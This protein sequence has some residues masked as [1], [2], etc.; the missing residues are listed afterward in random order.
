MGAAFVFSL[1]AFPSES[2]PFLG[3][4]YQTWNKPLGVWQSPEQM[5]FDFSEMER[6]GLRSARV[7]WVWGE[8]EAKEG[9]FDFSLPEKMVSLAKKHHIQIQPIIGFQWPPAW[10]GPEHRLS[11]TVNGTSTPSALM[12]YSDPWVRARFARAIETTVRHFRGEKQI[13]AWILGN[14]FAAIDFLGFRQ[15]GPVPSVNASQSVWDSFLNGRREAIAQIIG[16][17]CA[18]SKRADPSAK[19]TYAAIGVLFS[20]FDRFSTSEDAGEIARA[21]RDRGAPLDFIS[22]NS[23]LNLNSREPVFLDLSPEIFAGLTGLPVR[24]SEFGVTSTEEHLPSGE[25]EQALLLKAQALS[26]LLMPIEGAAHI[27][28]W[29][30]KPFVAKRERGF[31]IRTE[32]R[33]LKPV[34]SAMEGWLTELSRYDAEELRRKMLPNSA[35]EIVFLLPDRS[36]RASRWNSFLN[37]SWIVASHFRRLGY[38]VR[39]SELAAVLANPK[40]TDVLALVRHDRMTSGDWTKLV[41]GWNSGKIAHVLI[42]SGLPGESGTWEK[43]LGFQV[44][45]LRSGKDFAAQSYLL[46]FVGISQPPHVVVAAHSPWYW[47]SAKPTGAEPFGS[48]SVAKGLEDNRPGGIPLVYVKRNTRGGSV[49]TLTVGTGYTMA[50]TE[51]V[52]ARDE[53]TMNRRSQQGPVTVTRFPDDFWTAAFREL[54]AS[55]WL[56][57]LGLSRPS[58]LQEVPTRKSWLLSETRGLEGGGAIVYGFHSPVMAGELGSLCGS[59]GKES[60]EPKSLEIAVG[61]DTRAMISM[62][63]GKRVSVSGGVFKKEL[64]LCESDVWVSAGGLARDARDISLAKDPRPYFTERVAVIGNP[65]GVSEAFVRAGYEM[66]RGVAPTYHESE[67][68]WTVSSPRA[69]QE[70]APSEFVSAGLEEM[71]GVFPQWRLSLAA[72]SEMRSRALQ[73]ALPSGRC[74]VR[75]DLPLRELVSPSNW[76]NVTRLLMDTFQRSSVCLGST[77][78]TS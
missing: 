43:D 22:L 39:F 27:F 40:S 50:V 57:K 33:G 58:E 69:L 60:V 35:P 54:S 11:E 38:R 13:E 18:A 64:K 28:T 1:L 52:R 32:N 75:I 31:G 10:V 73:A 34:S 51:E 56:K 61:N 49:A 68:Q 9:K 65:A 48:F 42:S 67:K 66:N 78:D 30:E 4:A 24:L 55:L 45:S 16:D 6:L 21:C 7:E 17:A 44:E 53:A 8:I 3:M 2:R 19:R 63:T 5:D 71:A 47:F 72:W 29:A 25:V 62:T 46:P 15:L 76:I 23:Y 12:N 14:E 59:D 74:S 36:W 41:A 26:T 70:F 77:R 20:Q 37:E